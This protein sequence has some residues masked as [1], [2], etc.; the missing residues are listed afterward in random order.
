MRFYEQLIES[1]AA[2]RKHLLDAPAI[3]ACL[4]GNVT[5]A[6]YLAFLKR[7]STMCATPCRC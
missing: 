7:R 2:E 3:A 1:T 4:Q 5:P 6:T